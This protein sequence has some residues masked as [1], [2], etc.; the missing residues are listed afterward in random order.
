MKANFF[1]WSLLITLS[2]SLAN[3]S[4]EISGLS[5]G[6]ETRNADEKRLAHATQRITKRLERK[7]RSLL[8]QIARQNAPRKLPTMTRTRNNGYPSDEDNEE[9]EDEEEEVE[10]NQA[11]ILD[12]TKKSYL[13]EKEKVNKKMPPN[14]KNENQRPKPPVESPAFDSSV[15]NIPLS[16]V[17]NDMKELSKD[18]VPSKNLDSPPQIDPDESSPNEILDDISN[19]IKSNGKQLRNPSEVVPDIESD[20]FGGKGQ[21]LGATNQAKPNIES[22]NPNL[23]YNNAKDIDTN[24][25]G[26]ESTGSL[27]T[28]KSTPYFTKGDMA[29]LYAP[30]GKSNLNTEKNKG[31]SI[32]PN[33]DDKELAELL[34]QKPRSPLKKGNDLSNSAEEP[35]E[36]E[37]SDRLANTDEDNN[38]PDEILNSSQRISNSDE[39][40]NHTNPILNAPVSKELIKD[41][42]RANEKI[43]ANVS[44]DNY[45]NL[46][47]NPVSIVK[48]L[49]GVVVGSETSNLKNS[50][51]E[52]TSPNQRR[53]QPARESPIQW[54]NAQT[55]SNYK[56]LANLEGSRVNPNNDKQEF[57]VDSKGRIPFSDKRGQFTQGQQPNLN[58]SRQ[59]DDAIFR[60][61]KEL[62]AFIRTHD[63]TSKANNSHSQV[64]LTGIDSAKTQ[65]QEKSIRIDGNNNIDFKEAD[66][67][68]R[69]HNLDDPELFEVQSDVQPEKVK[70]MTRW[71]EKKA[72]EQKR[73]QSFV[74]SST[75]KGPGEDDP[76]SQNRLYKGSYSFMAP[77]TH[78]VPLM[79]ITLSKLPRSSNQDTSELINIMSKQH[80][81]LYGQQ[82]QKEENQFNGNSK[83]KLFA[84]EQAKKKLEPFNTFHEDPRKKLATSGLLQKSTSNTL[85]PS[86]QEIDEM[87]NKNEGGDI[88]QH[89]QSG[90]SPS[91][92]TS[93][94]QNIQNSVTQKPQIN[95]SKTI[96]FKQDFDNRKLFKRYQTNDSLIS[97][98]KKLPNEQFVIQRRT[99]EIKANSVKGISLIPR[100][101]IRYQYRDSGKIML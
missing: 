61:N 70:E 94:E 29:N 36:F 31:G 73:I 87:I 54:K 66:Y 63:Q 52:N 3:F 10:E 19:F 100:R 77:G 71:Q 18:K 84:Q 90:T 5:L 96:A 27:R 28:S 40:Q 67:N 14:Q 34:R 51:A 44:V 89:Q 33:S 57:D 92:K 83:L 20:R 1:L 8:R 38:R 6:L 42:P 43:R 59:Y 76:S 79:P 93:D 11:D 15:D 2:I 91:N 39:M 25:P 75:Y 45:P 17:L 78:P 24:S 65:F 13:P 86:E 72:M 58:L 23:N 81:R 46:T 85:V 32:S 35:Y 60:E 30:Y 98:L 64:H 68:T 69:S 47:G 48:R 4:E 97:P 101:D 37:P 21:K 22:S 12:F 82:D 88:G 99:P 16:P 26:I 7:Y 53:Y 74:R 49:N 95:S 80:A 55:Q 56:P 50:S 41:D 9:K 62:E